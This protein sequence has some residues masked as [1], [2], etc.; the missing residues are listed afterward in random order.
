MTKKT[1]ESEKVTLERDLKVKTQIVFINDNIKIFQDQN[2]LYHIQIDGIYWVPDSYTTYTITSHGLILE[3]GDG[4][5]MFHFFEELG[6]LEVPSES[7]EDQVN[8][9][10]EIIVSTHII[11]AKRAC[12]RSLLYIVETGSWLLNPENN[13]FFNWATWNNKNIITASL[14]HDLRKIFDYDLNQN[15]WV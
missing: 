3:K 4:T 1:A 5:N 9:F 12:G 7:N 6:F 10:S 13:Y 11:K 15:A 14:R 8:E 2:L